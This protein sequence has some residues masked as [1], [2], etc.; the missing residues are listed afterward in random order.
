M[1]KENEAHRME[2]YS[3]IKREH[4]SFATLWKKLVGTVL[5]EILHDF[6]NMYNVKR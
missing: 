2:H 3:V 6:N 4:C 1:D 5:T